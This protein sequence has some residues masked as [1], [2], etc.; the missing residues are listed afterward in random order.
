MRLNCKGPDKPDGRDFPPPSIAS[1]RKYVDYRPYTR[2]AEQQGRT[3][4]C[5]MQGWE[6]YVQVPIN[7]LRGTDVDQ[8]SLMVDLDAIG[9]FNKLCGIYYDGNINNGAYPR[10][11]AE[12]MLKHG[13]VEISPH[14]GTSHKL[15]EYWRN[16]TVSD[17]K[18]S[19]LTN[20]PQTI[21][22]EWYLSFSRCKENGGLITLKPH[23]FRVGFHQTCVEGFIQKNGKDVFAVRNSHGQAFGD[24]GDFYIT[25]DDLGRIMTDSY[26]GLYNFNMEQMVAWAEKFMEI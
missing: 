12:F 13:L 2:I 8:G 6:G 26:G 9:G 7:K 10:D 20:G 5:T 16:K 18:N 4:S 14:G 3:Q 1:Q 15:L 22:T 24:M 17:L 11:S 19:L 21:A 23:D 25:P